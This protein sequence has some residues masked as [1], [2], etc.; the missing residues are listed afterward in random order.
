[1]DWLISAYCSADARIAGLSGISDSSYAIL[2]A[3]VTGALAWGALAVW[4]GVFG[5]LR[6]HGFGKPIQRSVWWF[7]FFFPLAQIILTLLQGAGVTPLPCT[8]RAMASLVVTVTF[9]FFVY[10]LHRQNGNRGTNAKFFS[11]ILLPTAGVFAVTN[12]FVASVVLQ[13]GAEWASAFM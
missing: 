2:S 5:K 6:R 10:G 7:L 12:K 13:A 3:V 8:A 1:M 11:L 9:L 4:Y